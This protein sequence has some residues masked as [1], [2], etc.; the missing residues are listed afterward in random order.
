MRLIRRNLRLTERMH[1]E[2]RKLVTTK[3][4]PKKIAALQKTLRW[5]RNAKEAEIIF[6]NKQIKMAKQSFEQKQIWHYL[7]KVFPVV[8][9]RIERN[10]K[11]LFDSFDLRYRDEEQIIDW[12]KQT[13]LEKVADL[14]S[15]HLTMKRKNHFD[16]KLRRSF[17]MTKSQD[18]K[19]RHEFKTMR[20]IVENASSEV[21]GSTV[22]LKKPD[23]NRSKSQF[24]RIE[25]Q[26]QRV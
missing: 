14:D 19:A 7:T 9:F 2:N 26:S 24:H 21:E 10:R 3:T 20:Q 1:F 22:V 25:S 12:L 4:N 16:Q 11:I 17:L 6:E 15:F 23:P 5:A 13:N 8:L 18:I